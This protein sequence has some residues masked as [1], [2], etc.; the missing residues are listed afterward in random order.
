MISV[1]IDIPEP[2]AGELQRLRASFGDPLAEAIPSHV[3]LMSPAEVDGDLMPQIHQHLERVGALHRPFTMLLRS[4]GTFRPVS[5]VVFVQVAGGISECEQIERIIRTGPLK[6]VPPFYYHPHVTVAH[7][8][9]ETEMDRAFDELASY[10]CS[11]QV[12]AFRL[13]EHGADL[14][15][16]PVRTFALGAGVRSGSLHMP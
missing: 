9:D 12:G 6:R 13:Y 3:T 14:V 16:R 8:V 4:T 15:S 1:S 11:F 10:E 5:P 7:H 2:F